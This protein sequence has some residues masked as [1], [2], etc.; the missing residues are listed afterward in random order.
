MYLRRSAALLAASAALC[1]V[2]APA[3]VAAPAKDGALYGTSDPT[4][5]G[6]WRQSLALL[7]QHTA[8]V[9]PAKKAVRWLADQQ[10]DD[11]SFPSYRADTHGD[12]DKKSAPN[13]NSTG[14]AVQALAALGG[15]EKAVHKAVHWL[16]SVQNDD[17]GWGYTAGSPS[18]A[19]SVSLVIGS[20]AAAGEQPAKLTATH[21]ATPY[22]ALLGFQLGCD[23][24]PD[25]RGAFA[26][27]P[28]K[29]GGL[30]PNAD[31]T[32]AAALGGLGD[33]EVVRPAASAH[34]SPAAPLDC[35]S[36]AQHGKLTPKRAAEAGAAYL[37]AVLKGNKQHLQSAMPGA[38]DQPDWSNTADAVIALA[39]GGHH[40]AAGASLSWLE[41]HL[42]EW[43][44][45]KNDPAALSQLVLAA[46][47]TGAD[48]HDFGGVDLVERL[49]ATGPKPQ[50]ATPHPA[51]GAMASEK[52]GGHHS[53]VWV[54]SMIG[55]GLA[56]GIGVGLA[57]CAVRRKDAS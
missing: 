37:T 18:D 55:V 17:G 51:T 3:A 25:A 14:I 32:A 56:A 22:D 30:A 50:A 47:A 35:G 20:L 24:K 53:T 27:Q 46:H 42:G 13:T 40:K 8:H 41:K 29:K 16:E 4:Y 9:V 21:G 34:A 23:A 48:P 33:G 57:V 5:D 19:N 15:H 12:C 31:A 10:C 11:G 52:S 36:G 43:D 39:A 49:D 54:I 38:K 1:A 2:T 6:V 44:K 28:D 45:A 26:F 7:A